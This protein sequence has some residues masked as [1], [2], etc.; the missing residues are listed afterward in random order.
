[1]IPLL[2]PCPACHGDGFRAFFPC[3]TCGARG[4]QMRETVLELAFPPGVRSGA[5][6]DVS[7]ARLGVENLWLHVRVRVGDA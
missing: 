4:W 6:L 3:P 1:M 5:T 2:A 7:L